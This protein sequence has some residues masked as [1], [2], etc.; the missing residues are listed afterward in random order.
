MK[1]YLL[2]V[3][4]SALFFVSCD[5]DS[6]KE[7]SNADLTSKVDRLSFESRELFR[8]AMMEMSDQECYSLNSQLKSSLFS[9]ISSL[10]IEND[11]I[12]RYELKNFSQTKAD[13]YKSIFDAEEYEDLIP[14]ERLARL[15]NARGEIEI[16]GI[17]YKISPDGVYYF[18]KS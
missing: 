15:L 13:S 18:D 5:K 8:L 2:F 16:A 14:D 1:R 3:A 12:L 17:I 6:L 10:D 7:M 11:P 4:I 9:P